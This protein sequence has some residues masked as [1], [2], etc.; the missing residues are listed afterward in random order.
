M[1]NMYTMYELK[2]N[3]LNDSILSVFD[4]IKKDEILST[5][6]HDRNTT[7]HIEERVKEI[8]SE[9]VTE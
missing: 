1:T 2:Y 5:M 7:V 9:V 8:F 4:R 3:T 6:F